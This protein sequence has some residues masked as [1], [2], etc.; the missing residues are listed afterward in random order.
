MPDNERSKVD[1]TRLI[2]PVGFSN[3]PQNQ[4]AS[5]DSESFIHLI[6]SN[7]QFFDVSLRIRTGS[8]KEGYGYSR[9]FNN[10]DGVS[11]DLEGYRAI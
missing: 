5:R 1:P 7:Q 3:S 6:I 2:L 11:E 8:G 4:P 9:G 10:G